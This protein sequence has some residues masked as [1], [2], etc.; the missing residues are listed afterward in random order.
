MKKKHIHR[1]NVE[2]AQTLASLPMRSFYFLGKPGKDNLL[3][4]LEVTQLLY[5]RAD[6][7]R[8]SFVWG[9]EVKGRNRQEAQ[10][11]VQAGFPFKER[12]RGL[13]FIFMPD[14]TRAVA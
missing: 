4:M 12:F 8:E 5:Q 2:Q 14:E 13:R 7:H 10:E 11:R 6:H 1:A 9:C 3:D